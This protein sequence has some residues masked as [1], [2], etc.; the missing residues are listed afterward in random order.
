MESQEAPGHHGLQLARAAALLPGT[1]TAL[2]GVATKDDGRR[3]RVFRSH[4]HL[5]ERRTSGVAKMRLNFW[6]YNDYLCLVMVELL[7]IYA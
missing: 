2:L 5:A 3:S 6:L 7:V 4:R 1:A